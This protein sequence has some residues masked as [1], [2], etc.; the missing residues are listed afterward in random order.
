MA[1]RL[2]DVSAIGSY[3]FFLKSFIRDAQKWGEVVV[4]FAD[5]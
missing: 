3:K 5:A 1:P 2:A 4:Q